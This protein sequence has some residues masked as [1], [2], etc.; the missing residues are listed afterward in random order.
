M[1]RIIIATAFVLV[2]QSHVALPAK[3]VTP[4]QVYAAHSS[5]EV[6]DIIEST[7]NVVVDFSASWCGPCKRM[8]PILHALAAELPTITIITVDVEDFDDTSKI[9]NVKRMPTFVFFKSG[10]KVGF[11]TGEQSRKEFKSLLTR[12]F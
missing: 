12:Y 1:K 6:L 2:A 8:E 5:S 11:T 9:H 10:K 3:S 4:G 7:P